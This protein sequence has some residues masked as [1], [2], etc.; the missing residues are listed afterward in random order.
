MQLFGKANAM[1]YRANNFFC[2]FFL[3]VCLFGWCSG[4]TKILAHYGEKTFFVVEK[5]VYKA[6]LTV[7]MAWIGRWCYVSMY[8]AMYF[9]SSNPVAIKKKNQEERKLSNYNYRLYILQVKAKN[10]SWNTSGWSELREWK[11]QR[12]KDWNRSVFKFFKKGTF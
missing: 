12:R 2:E 6:I 1:C 3:L 7:V 5:E 11:K 4:R 8:V 9:L 10:V